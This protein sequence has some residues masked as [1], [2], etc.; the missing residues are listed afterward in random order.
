MLTAADTPTI[1]NAVHKRLGKEPGV[2][3]C[4][5]KFTKSE[6]AIRVGIVATLGLDD[7]IV[8]RSMFDLPSE[9]EHA[10]LV[11][12]LDEIA[13]QY[14][15]ARLDFFRNGGVEGEK[16]VTGT[17]LRGRWAQYGMRVA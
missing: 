11:N 3:I 9:F 5:I 17:G 16:E 8:T 15:A 6:I 14:K 4:D 7:R 12:E 10:H 1:R 13:E 2:K